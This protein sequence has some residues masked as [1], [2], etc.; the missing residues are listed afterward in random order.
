MKR[1]ALESVCLA[2]PYEQLYIENLIFK[3][4]L[5]A[6]NCQSFYTLFSYL[7]E[8]FHFSDLAIMFYAIKVEELR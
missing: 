2:C 8:S 7:N 3:S 5:E 6:R 1:Q 4:A